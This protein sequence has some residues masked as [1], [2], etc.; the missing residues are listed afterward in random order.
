MM[1]HQDLLEEGKI[2]ELVAALRAIDSSTPEVAEKIRVEAGVSKTIKSAC[3]RPCGSLVHALLDGQLVHHETLFPAQPVFPKS[4][5]STGS[6]F[7]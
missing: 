1:I 2:K 3:A 5:P 4:G 6:A 7:V